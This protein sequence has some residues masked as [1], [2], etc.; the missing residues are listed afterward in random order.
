ML[1]VVSLISSW[2]QV[3]TARAP[4]MKQ[5]QSFGRNALDKRSLVNAVKISVEFLRFLKQRIL[6][7]DLA[8]S[9]GLEALQFFHL[10][11]LAW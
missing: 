11:R 2:L 8:E 6:R 9:G 3:M 7:K 5:H 1:Q 4:Q 10:V